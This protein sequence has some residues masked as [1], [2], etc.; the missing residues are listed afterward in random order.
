[1]DKMMREN[2]RCYQLIKKREKKVENESEM[3]ELY[4]TLEQ[5]Y[6]HI[7]IPL[8]DESLFIAVLHELIPRNLAQAKLIQLKNETIAG[9]IFLLFEGKI[10]SWYAGWNREYSKYNPNEFG[11]WKMLQWGCINNYKV[12]DFGGAGKPTERYGVRDYKMQFGGSLVNFG[13]YQ[14]FIHPYYYKLSELGFKIW[15]KFFSRS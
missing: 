3:K 14:S 10:H 5:T 11:T 15:R 4:H 6:K 12:F 2:P 7:K 1:V 13:R 9:K 8:A